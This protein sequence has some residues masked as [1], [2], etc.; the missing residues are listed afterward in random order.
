M[1]LPTENRDT[2]T[3]ITESVDGDQDRERT[4]LG[5]LNDMQA[6][7]LLLDLSGLNLVDAGCGSGDAARKMAE[8]G[9]TVLGVEPDP[10]QAERN[11]AQAPTSG[12]TLVEAG[13]EALPAEGSSQDGV[14]FFRSLHHVPPG[15]MGPAL[16]EAARVLR[17]GG[18]LYV[19]E[20]GMGC[21]FSDMMLPFND[22]TEVRTLAQQALNQTA[23]K[24]LGNPEK[25]LYRQYPTY[26]DFETLIE[27]FTN[28]SFHKITRQMI[29]QPIVRE[30]FEQSRTDNG[31]IFEQTM[32]VNL[33]RV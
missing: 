5:D 14:F 24:L 29:D 20:P 7:D 2:M 33:Y 9:A 32:L 8:R 26:P 13:A 15:L 16:K 11:R 6:L 17:S 1:N 27:R 10:A 19:V 23:G 22:E 28:I 25:Y 12:V 18:F 4:E 30:S 21:S 3:A 31:Y